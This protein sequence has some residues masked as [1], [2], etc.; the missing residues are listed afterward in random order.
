MKKIMKKILSSIK[1][2]WAYMD[3]K[4]TIIAAT[5]WSIVEP[6]VI[7]IYPNG[8]PHDIAVTMTIIGVF[9]TALGLGHKGVKTFQAGKTGTDS[10]TTT[11]TE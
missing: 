1:A 6:T 5:Y 2:F 10:T 8:T 9:L 4:K 3:G 11:P 7:A